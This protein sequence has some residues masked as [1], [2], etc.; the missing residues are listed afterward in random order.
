MAPKNKNIC[1][2]VKDKHGNDLLCPLHA[3]KKKNAVFDSEFNECV[4]KD[5]VERYC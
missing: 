2:I 4:E 5:V 3:V 1:F